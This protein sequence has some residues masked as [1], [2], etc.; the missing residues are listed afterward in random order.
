VIKYNKRVPVPVVVHKTEK[1]PVPVKRT[2]PCLSL[3]WVTR[4]SGTAGRQSPLESWLCWL[5]PAISHSFIVDFHRFPIAMFED[6]GEATIT[7]AI[8]TFF[9]HQWGNACEMICGLVSQDQNRE[10]EG[11][12]AKPSQDCLQESEGSPNHDMIVPLGAI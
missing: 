9:V 11:T 12:C 8:G 7:F 3:P 2:G 5:F 6:S 1:I 10:G 4:G